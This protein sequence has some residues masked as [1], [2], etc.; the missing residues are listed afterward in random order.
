MTTPIANSTGNVYYSKISGSTNLFFADPATVGA[1]TYT[2]ANTVTSSA[3]AV[4]ATE[5]GP[6]KGSIVDRLTIAA[7][8]TTGNV[9]YKDIASLDMSGKEAITFYIKSSIDVLSGVLRFVIDNTSA[10][11]SPLETLSI[12]ALTAGVWQR[13]LLRLN[14]PSALTAIISVGLDALS[15][16]GTVVVDIYQPRQMDEFEGR[17]SFSITLNVDE[18]EGT[19]YQSIGS[20][21]YEPGFS[22]ATVTIEGH[23]EGAPV[24]EKATKYVIGLAE[25]STLGNSFI[26]NAFYTSFTPSGNFSALIEYPLSLRIS[27]A[28][29]IPVT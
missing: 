16:P 5:A 14:D 23:K 13:V 12:P 27:G 8:F 18:L 19:D 28:L 26:C 21:E 1:P 17:K 20:R 22:N 9:C 2:A 7:G 3:Y 4:P 10:C 25:S 6:A 29:Q 11:V 15:D 24:F